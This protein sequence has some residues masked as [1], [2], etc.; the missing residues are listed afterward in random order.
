LSCRDTSPSSLASPIC[1]SNSSSSSRSPNPRIDHCHW[2][3]LL[4]PFSCLNFY[5]SINISHFFFYFILH[6]SLANAMLLLH[7][8]SFLFSSIACDEDA[9]EPP[10]YII[11]LLLISLHIAI[12]ISFHTI[13]EQFLSFKF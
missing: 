8:T 6:Y 13:L 10:L 1:S 11:Q 5:F 9:P 4:I 12:I 7:A 3:T 2:S